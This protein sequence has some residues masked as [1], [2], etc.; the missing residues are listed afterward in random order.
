MRTRF[1]K[2]PLLS[3]G[4]AMVLAACTHD[5]VDAPDETLSG[6]QAKASTSTLELAVPRLQRELESRVY[7][8]D[9][10][11]V[12]E[13]SVCGPTPFQQAYIES[14]Y[15]NIDALGR[16]WGP[17]YMEMNFYYSITDESKAYFGA[18]GEYTNL[19][20]KITRNLENFW[21][22]H[23]EVDVRGQHNATLNDKDKIISILTFWYGLSNQVAASYA[24]YFVDYV[25]V[26]STFLV[27]SPLLSFDGFAIALDGFLGQG[28][29]I[30]IGDGIVEIVSESGVED[31]VVWNGILAHEWAHQVQFDHMDDW[32]PNGAAD[33]VPEA[34]RT[35]ELEADFFAAY[36]MTHKR[37]ATYNWKRV[38]EFLELY[39]NIGDCQFTNNGHH[40]TPLQRMR[41]AYKG[42]EL[43]RAAQKEG[44][45]LDANIVHAVFLSELGE[46]VDAGVTAQ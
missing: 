33:N 43:A 22:M 7:A 15:S 16:E 27:E 1:V 14:F 10:P 9:F 13:P 8:N 44:Q 3:V 21:Q 30:V 42:Y 19:V 24:D 4:M 5:T 39:Y 28:D 17:T 34:T 6:V 41:A 12:V 29:L 38:K 45:V 37:G 31:K 40:G 18:N 32:Y 20:H 26:E 2:F 23:D 36:Y 35:T 25:N 46:I 11:K